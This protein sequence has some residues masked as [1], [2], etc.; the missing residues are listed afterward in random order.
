MT[1]PSPPKRRRPLLV[2]ALRSIARQPRRLYTR[3]WLWH[4][5]SFVISYPKSGRTW[6]RL[7][8]ASVLASLTARP[9]TLDVHTYGDPGKGIPWVFFTHDGAGLSK[10]EATAGDPHFYEGKTVLL[11]V[12]DPRDVVI[13]HYHQVRR[14][15][16]DGPVVTDLDSFIRGPLGIDR[17]IAFMNR[18]AAQRSVPGRFALLR[19]EQI[20]EDRLG[21]LRSAVDFF[22]IRGVTEHVLAA[23][24]E[25]GSFERMRAI[26][27]GGLLDDR[28]LQP[29]NVDDPDSYKVRRGKIGSHADELT[30]AQVRFLDD[31]IRE[32]LSPEFAYYVR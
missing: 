28:R 23:A 19:Y 27:A 32:A 3:H 29:R 9:L 10:A 31:R 16:R 2:R 17:I 15:K 26:E 24:A 1:A 11:L 22:G 13:S 25:R 30:P 20:H 4:H 12:R 8:L 7:M 18:W 5:G 6:L 14:R 21:A